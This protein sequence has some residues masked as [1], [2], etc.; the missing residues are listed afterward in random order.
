MLEP[1]IDLQACNIQ[2][3]VNLLGLKLSDAELS[4]L[5]TGN[6]ISLESRVLSEIGSVF[7]LAEA[8]LRTK[9]VKVKNV[10]FCDLQKAV[11]EFSQHFGI[12]IYCWDSRTGSKCCLLLALVDGK[13]AIRVSYLSQEPSITMAVPQVLQSV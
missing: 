11:A 3:A 6:S 1:T 13:P 9:L 10:T 4:E 2:K 12:P 8:I 7:I 5:K